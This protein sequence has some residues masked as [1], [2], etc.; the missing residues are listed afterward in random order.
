MDSNELPRPQA[1]HVPTGAQQSQPL[2]DPSAQAMGQPQAPGVS[3]IP[4]AG[5]AVPQSQLT[6]A[7]SD[8]IEKE[9]VH[10]VK[11]VVEQ[12]RQNPHEQSRQLAYLRAEYLKK[13][14]NRDIKLDDA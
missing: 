3:P 5:M 7:D 9:W 6:A 12:N 11:E 10:K 2:A 1:Q 8:L 13:R 14:Y 4:A